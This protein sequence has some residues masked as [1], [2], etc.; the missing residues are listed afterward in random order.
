MNA[1]LKAKFVPKRKADKMAG[2]VVFIIQIPEYQIFVFIFQLN[3]LLK[4]GGTNGLKG[5]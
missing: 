1:Q 4:C 5:L 2:A 3:C